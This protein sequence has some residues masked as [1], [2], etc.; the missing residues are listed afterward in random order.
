MLRADGYPVEIAR[1]RGYRLS[2]GTPTPGVFQRLRRGAF[3]SSYSYIGTTDST[4]EEVAR[5]G[6]SGALEGTVVVAERQTSGR[7][8][9]GRTWV[10]SPGGTLQFSLLLRPKFSPALLPLLSLAAGLALVEAAGVGGLKWPNDLLAPDGRKLG[11]VLLEAG[12]SGEEIGQVVLGIGL[13]IA[14]GG[15]PEGSAVLSEFVPVAR[16][17]LLA[18][19]LERLERWYHRVDTPGTVVRGWLA[20]NLTVGRRIQVEATSGLVEGLAVGLGEDG[21][22]ELETGKGRVQLRSGDVALI[23]G[24]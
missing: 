11:G 1:G 12:L 22:L 2:P 18:D 9:R 5:L 14:P 24:L 17:R 8:R 16:D 7:G 15:L 13:N 20:N 4:Q 19:L 23:G 6:R 10:G 3:G 21:S